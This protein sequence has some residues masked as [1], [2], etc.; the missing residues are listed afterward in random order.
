MRITLENEGMNVP[1]RAAET[2]EKDDT[3][4]IA[5]VAFR[6]REGVI[7]SS[8]IHIESLYSGWESHV[9]TS[10]QPQQ[11]ER[12]AACPDASSFA[13]SHSRSPFLP[14]PAFSVRRRSTSRSSIFK[15]TA[16]RITSP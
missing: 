6:G 2:R 11:S 16:V 9:A 12:E 15:V 10:S 3:A 4:A 7:R 13:C 14:P 8:P 1:T 5:F